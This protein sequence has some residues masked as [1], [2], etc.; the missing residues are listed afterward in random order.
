MAEAKYLQIARIIKKRIQDGTYQSKDPLPD[1][2]ALAQE[3]GVSRLT[4]KKALDGLERKGFVYKQSGLGTF[5]LGTIPIHEKKDIPTTGFI[6]LQDELERKDITNQVIHFS[7]EFPNE[8]IQK[9]LQIKNNDPI[10]NILRLRLENDEPLYLEHIYMPIS[11]IPHLDYTILNNS[12]SDYLRDTL[13]L[14][15]GI[16][17]R[18]I[19]ATKAK[20]TDQNFLKAKENDPIL[21]L[22]QVVWLSNGEPIEYSYKRN[23]FDLLNYSIL[24]TD[25][26]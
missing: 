2:E 1:Q 26:Y 17:Y 20:K 19:R 24:E 13:N 12:I 6:S 7:I 11:L 15:F 21:E 22:E 9:N 23:R 8:K 4:V 5:V 18:K 16:A 25:N 3:L 10:Y 14:K